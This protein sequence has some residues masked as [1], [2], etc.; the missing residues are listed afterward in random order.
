MKKQR[1]I[2]LIALIITI[3]VL[4]ILAGVALNSI[5]GQGS[6]IGNAENA[7]DEYNKK[8][9]EEK[10][11]LEQLEEYFKNNGDSESAKL[12]L[13]DKGESWIKV[14]VVDENY[15]N[16]QFSI[17]NG[18]YVQS[19]AAEYK[20][21]NLE[22]TKVTVIETIAEE[23][24]THIIKAK[25]T[26]KSTGE[27]EELNTIQVATEVLVES[28]QVQYF[29]YEDNGE[30]ITITELVPF[31]EIVTDTSNYS[32]WENFFNNLQETIIV[33]SYIE[34]KPVTK[35]SNKFIKQ[36]ANID[37]FIKPTIIY[38]LA[39]SNTNNL[40]AESEIYFEEMGETQNEWFSNIIFIFNRE[41]ILENAIAYGENQLAVANM[42][43]S[44][45][46][47]YLS[48][49]NGIVQNGI[50]TL[51]LP[52]TIKEITKQDLINLSNNYDKIRSNSDLDSDPDPDPDLGLDPDPEPNPGSGSD[53]P[54]AGTNHASSYIIMSKAI[55]E[56][57]DT[58]IYMLGQT[59]QE[60]QIL[61]EQIGI[62]WNTFTQV[63][64][65]E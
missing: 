45:S 37:T 32:N 44:S 43:S 38:G 26:N 20:F 55:E 46:N 10:L 11:A 25:A 17:D 4:L 59:N 58:T 33:P 42:T 62:D 3:I 65:Q 19:N 64:V 56:V 30:G 27:I 2:T 53:G 29:K 16:Y 23:G 14:K 57:N 34:G 9:E 21:S 1:G 49:Q 7:V 13:V 63:K 61:K 48:I 52:P 6:L 39:Y 36:V 31:S 22:I 24:A 15:E 18:E 8:V 35:V 60:K 41:E 5:F 47:L 12:Q 51:I 28:D 54:E 40:I 50:I